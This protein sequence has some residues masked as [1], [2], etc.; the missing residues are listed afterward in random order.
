MATYVLVHGAWHTGELFE[1]VAEPIRAKG[2]T[3]HCPT[4]AGNNPGDDRTIGLDVAITSIVT[5]LEE[6]NLQE[7]VLLGHSYG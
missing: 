1:A 6:H 3:V 2:H 4:V 7:G 5:Y